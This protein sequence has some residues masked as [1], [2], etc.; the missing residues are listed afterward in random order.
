MLT[1]L[2]IHFFKCSRAA[3]SVVGDGIWQKF[4][5]IQ[6]FMVVLVTYKNDDDSIKNEST[7]LLT[8]FL[9]LYVYGEFFSHSRADNSVDPGQILPNFKPI[10]VLYQSLV[11]ARMN[12]MRS[13]MKVLECSQNYT[14]IVQMLKGS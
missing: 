9:L 4:K 6:A 10:Q 11:H 2:Y 5:L 3:T 7:G 1:T 8:T 12:K 13:K 14:L